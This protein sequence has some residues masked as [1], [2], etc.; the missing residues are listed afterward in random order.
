MRAH[1][2]RTESVAADQHDVF[3]PLRFAFFPFATAPVSEA[4]AIT[5][6]KSVI[7]SW[8][9]GLVIQLRYYKVGLFKNSDKKTGRQYFRFSAPSVTGKPF[10][11]QT[12]AWLT[13]M[14]S[15]VLTVRLTDS[16]LPNHTDRSRTARRETMNCRFAR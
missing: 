14:R 12:R 10:K 11:I 7:F 3:G 13:T 1:D 6:S 5:N 15:R 4:V 16:R 9:V 8:F 2:V